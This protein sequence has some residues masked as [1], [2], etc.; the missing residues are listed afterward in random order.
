[1]F[2]AGSN[3]AVCLVVVYYLGLLE[4]WQAVIIDIGSLLVVVCN[5]LKVLYLHPSETP[6]SW[7]AFSA[8]TQHSNNVEQSMHNKQALSEEP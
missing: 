4:F 2:L 7:L 1:M 3:E 8:L 6:S 5:G